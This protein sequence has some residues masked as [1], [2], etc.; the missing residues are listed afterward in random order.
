MTNKNLSRRDFLR[1]A[2]LFAGSMAVQACIPGAA[3]QTENVKLVYQDWRT[4][5]FPA[6]AQEEL[7]RF[8][9]Q[10]PNIRVFY[11]PDP[12]DVETS[13]L[14]DAKAGHAPDVFAA[15]C[16][17]FPILG[18][19]GVCLDLRP[20]IEKNIDQASL[21]DWDPAQFHA[22][23]RRDGLQYGLPKYHGALAL[24]YNK[25][26]F[27][28][29]KVDY[30]DGSWNHDDYL[31]AMKLLTHDTDNDGKIDIWGSMI[32]ISWER[33]QV[34][35]NAWGGNLVDPTNPSQSRMA[36][37][38]ALEAMEW[39]RAR[40]WD[41]KVMATFRDVENLSTRDAFSSG[42][43][44]MVED[45]SWAL[46]DILVKSKFRIGVSPLPSGPAKR[47]TLAT[48]DG[49]G[50]WANTP[51]PNQ[52]GE[53]LKY[54]LSPDYGRAM[55]RAN[56]LQ[57]ARISLVDEWVAM[58]RAEYPEQA[59][60]V[61]LEAFADGHKNGYSV[62]TEIFTNMK[63]ATRLASDAWN[64]IFNLGQAP[65]DLMKS[66]SDEINKTQLA[67]SS[68]PAACTSCNISGN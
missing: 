21:D 44:A 19:Q 16:T 30:P 9:A 61:A 67:A 55:A 32:D 66:V 54:L 56:Y 12:P 49:F 47:V 43:L 57:P 62:T 40:M 37:S 39:L 68:L 48:T 53:L 38:K 15:C 11:T 35:V 7:A 22:L 50:I 10:H 64:T 41:D 51:Y 24:Y 1:L 28:Q 26:V 17:F 46:K 29:F 18:Q 63:D 5:W 42:R 14:A 13:L 20:F 58:I 31:A 52:A 34:K 45:G 36:E 2:G 4:D 6:M 33:I 59:K 23:A 60:D 8:T 3:S 65:V 25:D 27:D